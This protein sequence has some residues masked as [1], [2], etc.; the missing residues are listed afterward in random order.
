MVNLVASLG[1]A[2]FET[3]SKWGARGAKIPNGL[4]LEKINRLNLKLSSSNK[5]IELSC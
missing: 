4:K 1:I 2:N 5:T 3:N